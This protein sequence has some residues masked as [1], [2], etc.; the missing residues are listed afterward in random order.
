MSDVVIIGNSSF[1]T[2]VAIT[3]EEQCRG[4]MFQKN[5]NPMCF[6]FE[7]SNIRKFW[8]KNTIAALDIIFCKS[9][10]V[11]SIHK[12]E[13]LSKDFVGPNSPTDLVVEF[14]FGT[15]QASGISVGDQVELKYSVPTLAK[16][17]ANKY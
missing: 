9:G 5:P 10:K 16:K 11:V 15:A 7:S 14:P 8:M 1:K 17:F 2:S 4:L 6:P 13:P 12:G 3:E